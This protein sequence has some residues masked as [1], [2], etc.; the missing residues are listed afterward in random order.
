MNYKIAAL[1]LLINASL[2]SCTKPTN[3][4]PNPTKVD[5]V[6]QAPQWRIKQILSST[7]N[8]RLS[9]G[10]DTTYI[11]Y[12]SLGRFS[13]INYRALIYA[14][15]GTGTNIGYSANYTSTRNY[16]YLGNTEKIKKLYLNEN[17]GNQ[18]V[19]EYFYNTAQTQL[20]RYYLHT[21]AGTPQQ[22]YIDL[23]YNN[24][25]LV[26]YKYL[27]HYSPTS[28]DTTV[29]NMTYANNLITKKQDVRYNGG[30]TN[31]F[32]YE[33][34]AA[35]NT[36]YNL[37]TG[38]YGNLPPDTLRKIYFTWK[39]SSTPNINKIKRPD[40][41]FEE[42]INRVGILFYWPSFAYITEFDFFNLTSNGELLDSYNFTYN[43]Y[44]TMVKTMKFQYELDSNQN[45]S[46]ITGTVPG[47]TTNASMEMKIEYE[48][49]K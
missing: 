34:D 3:S 35:G 46:K 15:T 29:T 19:Y 14:Y 2:F 5:S 40:R 31:I 11:S 17:S 45:I 26:G 41:T 16:E 38:Q 1:L 47:S 32:T 24:D 21:L 37:A 12:D 36:V 39:P 9:R 49:I 13:S 27:Q 10:F 42:Y 43:K 6:D 28:I 7:V 8:I 18:V 25:K 30:N 48:K 4:D 23:T 22:D 33:Y 44:T 20:T